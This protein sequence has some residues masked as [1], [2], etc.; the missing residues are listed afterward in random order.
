MQVKVGDIIIWRGPSGN[1]ARWQIASLYDSGSIKTAI[2]L[3]G[4][5][6][7][8]CVVGRTYTSMSDHW[9]YWELEDEFIQ[10]VKEVREDAGLKA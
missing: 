4:G 6:A 2:Y 7:G 5:S 9:D 10:W 1:G 3:G 8:R